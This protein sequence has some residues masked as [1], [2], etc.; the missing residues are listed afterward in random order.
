MS[1]SGN[2][3]NVIEENAFQG[4][5]SLRTLNLNSNSL[6]QWSPES[7]NGLGNLFTLNFQR[8]PFREIPEN[9]FGK[10]T[11]LQSLDLSWSTTSQTG[12]SFNENSFS[13]LGDLR[14]LTIFSRQV[15]ELPSGVFVPLRNIQQI[16]LSFNRIR[17]L[18]SDAFGRLESLHSL[19]FED[20]N[21][22]KIQPNF[23]EN[24]PSLT[25]FN[26]LRNECIERSV[27]GVNTI[28]LN[29]FSQCFINWENPTTTPTTTT[30]TEGGASS[31]NLV[32]HVLVIT[33]AFLLALK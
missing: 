30:T 16:E 28:D 7:F 9:G 32:T 27:S 33:F 23:F 25:L 8:N 29:P 14:T 19:R 20:N 10:L 18:N 3:I 15:Q 2:V 13:N 5:I 24:L 26:G 11:A 17:R 4:L 31:V 12:L 1:L 6:L 21:I 22:N